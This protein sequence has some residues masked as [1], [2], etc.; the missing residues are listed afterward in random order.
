[1]L[2]NKSLVRGAGIAVLCLAVLQPVPPVSATDG[3]PIMDLG[4]FS[5]IKYQQKQ[6]FT[7][8]V[9]VGIK[10]RSFSTKKVTVKI[11][12]PILFENQDQVNHRLVFLPGLDNKM[13]L[14]Y[15]SP[16][17]EPGERWGLEIHTFGVFPFQC[18]LHPEER[19]SFTVK[20]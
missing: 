16:V 20:L 5:W 8:I 3:D 15:T 10:D 11:Y 7:E 18:T 13:D 14:A 9:E 6:F 12:Q 19:G 2:D 1:M 17:I 4:I